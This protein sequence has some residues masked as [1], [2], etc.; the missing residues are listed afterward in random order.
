MGDIL[1]SVRV[2]KIDVCAPFAPHAFVIEI[3]HVFVILSQS[4]THK[5]EPKW[6]TSYGQE[7]FSAR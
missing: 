2:S 4:S 3:G 1:T 7:L 5:F 6:Q